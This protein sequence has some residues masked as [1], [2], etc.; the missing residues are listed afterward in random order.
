MA[1]LFKTEKKE[2]VEKVRNYQELYGEDKLR[3]KFVA[4]EK[5]VVAELH[6]RGHRVPVNFKARYNADPEVMGRL[7]E[8]ARKVY[9]KVTGKK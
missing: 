9:L 1:K 4:A 8:R 3:E 2:F 7:F 6:K 5:K